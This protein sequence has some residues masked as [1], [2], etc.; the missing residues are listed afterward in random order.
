MAI[1]VAKRL[2]EKFSDFQMVMAGKE[3]PLTSTIKEMTEK[4]GLSGKII[5]PGY[6]NTQEKEK[7]ASEYDIYICTNRID[8]AP[9]SLIEFMS[10]G[11][12]V[13]SVNTGGIPYL[14]K[15]GQN[16][17]LVDPDDDEAMF[18]KICLLIENPSLA[19][20]IRSNALE[21]AQQYDEKYIIP[22]WKAL[23]ENFNYG[24]VC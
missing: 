23:M 9:V 15:D 3:G 22:K 13:V 19:K 10:F 6:I 16:G 18:A 17:L 21:Y 5:F 12:P 8:N 14:I 4:N 24:P 20:S 2:S 7:F 1:R 11:L